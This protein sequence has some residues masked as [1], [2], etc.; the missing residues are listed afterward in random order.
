[1]LLDEVL[2]QDAQLQ[3]LVVD[4]LF[5][6]RPHGDQSEWAVVDQLERVMPVE[7]DVLC[8]G[9]FD[10]LQFTHEGGGEDFNVVD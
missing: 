1:M 6:H 5:C 9:F 4:E 3:D 2:D 10:L 8:D 7:S